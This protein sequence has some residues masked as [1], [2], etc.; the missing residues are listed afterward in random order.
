MGKNTTNLV[1]ALGL[2]TVVFAGYYLYTTNSQP[3]LDFTEN[4]QIQQNM[5]NNTRVFIE[6]RQILDKVTLN[7][8]LFEDQRFNSLRSY[9][10]P[11]LE[12]PIGR[13][14]PFAEPNSAPQ[15]ELNL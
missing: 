13:P 3:A 11:I 14:N 5:L 6:R 12:R 9:T 8:N 10:T 7:I 1:T 4:D 2:I 15:A